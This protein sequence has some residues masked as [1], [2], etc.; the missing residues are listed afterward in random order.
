MRTLRTLDQELYEL[1]D[2]EVIFRRDDTLQMVSTFTY[3]SG[4]LI[5]ESMFEANI[6]DL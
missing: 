3:V 4:E 5:N 6:P 2:D 1:E